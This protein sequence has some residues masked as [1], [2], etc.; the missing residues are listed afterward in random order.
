[1]KSPMLCMD[2]GQLELM[3]L[4]RRRTTP[5]K[6]SKLNQLCPPDLIMYSVNANCE[7]ITGVEQ[8]PDRNSVF[9]LVAGCM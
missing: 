8:Q 9:G 4:M 3:H 6:I 7:R 1:M 2:K 5:R